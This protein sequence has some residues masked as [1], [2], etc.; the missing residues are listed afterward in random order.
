MVNPFATAL[1]GQGK[2][3]EE[4]LE[5]HVPVCCDGGEGKGVRLVGALSFLA[6]DV[7]EAPGPRHHGRSPVFV[8]LK[9]VLLQVV[10]VYV[11]ACAV[12][13]V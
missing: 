7:V 13:G 12:A 1:L 2:G 10:A 5:G 6:L 4:V 9:V 8:A 3:G 11:C